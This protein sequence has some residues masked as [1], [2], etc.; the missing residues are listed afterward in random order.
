[1]NDF[2]RFYTFIRKPV[3]R[4]SMKFIIGILIHL[5]VPAVSMSNGLKKRFYSMFNKVDKTINLES[6]SCTSW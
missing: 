5:T 1:M 6:A 3:K 2:E 4:M